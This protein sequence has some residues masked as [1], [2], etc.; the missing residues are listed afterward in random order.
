MNFTPVQIILNTAIQRLTA[1]GS[2]TPRL[3]A[4]VLLAHTLGY[5][6]RTRLYLY[7]D[8]PLSPQELARFEN[9]LQ[10]REHREPVAYLTGYKE[11]FGL[12]FEVNPHVLIP[13]PETE[14][15]VETTLEI[16]DFALHAFGGFTSGDDKSSTVNRQSKIV[17]V[18]TG[19]GCLAV[20][21]AKHLPQA[22][23][24]AVDLSGEALQ[25]AR[26]NAKRH[27]VSERITFVQGDL[28]EPILTPVDIIIS[29]PPYVSQP[30]LAVAQPEVSRYEPRLALDGGPNGVEIIQR[31]LLQAVSKLKPGGS[32]LIE[33]GSGQG[34]V[35]KELARQYFSA[36][37]IEIRP[38][39]A[40]LDRLLLLKM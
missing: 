12:D 4:E 33:I 22:A 20:T 9:L 29:N 14:L 27:G 6:E 19:S 7:P 21:L 37:H 24:F 2:D 18:G 16:Y 35:V 23:V 31:L 36:A 32:L 15:L 13:R 11:F 8:H 30:E 17:D 38:D 10:R 25:T 40:G 3:D 26:R 1:A 28:L 39:L 5:E 34:N